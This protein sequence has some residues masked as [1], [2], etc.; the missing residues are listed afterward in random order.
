MSVVGVWDHFR[1]MGEVSDGDEL[2][3]A[4]SEGLVWERVVTMVQC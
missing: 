3:L 4:G 1:A 2:G